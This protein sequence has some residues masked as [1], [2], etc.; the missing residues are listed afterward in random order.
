VRR[1]Q[2]DRWDLVVPPNALIVIPPT[3]DRVAAVEPSDRKGTLRTIRLKQPTADPVAI[4]V[5]VQQARNGPLVPVGPFLLKGAVPQQGQI[6]VTAPARVTPHVQ[7]VAEAVYALSP[8]E[9]TEEEKKLYPGSLAYR[10]GLQA[11]PAGPVV[12]PLFL[13]DISRVQPVVE[14]KV[15]HSLTWEFAG[16]EGPSGWRVHTVVEANVLHTDVDHLQLSFPSGYEF[17]DQFGLQPS[18]DWRWPESAD[19][20]KRGGEVALTPPR[21]GQVKLSFKGRVGPIPPGSR[22]ATLPL[23]RLE[24]TIDRGG[25]QVSVALPAGQEIIPAA[26]DTA[27]ESE[28]R[29]AVNRRV[30][31]FDRMPEQLTTAW[32]P[33]RPDLAVDGKALVRFSGRQAT[34]RQS[35][36]LPDQRPAGEPLRVRIPEGLL[37][38]RVTPP[39]GKTL[40]VEGSGGTTYE[41]PLT[42]P[43]DAARPVIL[44][45]VVNLPENLGAPFSL[46]L[47]APA[48]ATRGEMRVFLW[49]PP[50]T[51]PEVVGG[52]WEARL[53]EV[54]EADRYPSAVLV[55][56]R[57]DA[58]S[59]MS[60]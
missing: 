41:V 59:T 19:P 11:A 12:P 6:L 4:A 52:P 27:W 9:A 1:G 18:S 25:H 29:E 54:P 56:R 36:W 21:K 8:R 51:R 42:V 20:A 39:G 40:S 5:Q 33:Y 13:L 49:S 26:R 38:L 55:A 23:P 3:E 53:E 31:K 50:G 47:V 46:P 45:Y 60:A 30:W 48:Q 32:Q 28:T 15:T 17:D 44:E 10:Y 2:T 22:L 37:G 35:L 43:P 7:A 14:A 24:G 16:A 57:P 34:V 58:R